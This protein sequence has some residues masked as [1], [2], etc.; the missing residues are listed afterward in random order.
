M[1]LLIG[2][3]VIT[4]IALVS[5][6]I[7]RIPKPPEKVTQFSPCDG[8]ILDRETVIASQDPLYL[9]RKLNKK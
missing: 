6:Q 1:E 9:Y 4:F 2:E 3:F 8:G 7:R 5:R